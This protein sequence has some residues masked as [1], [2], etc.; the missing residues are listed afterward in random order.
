MSCLADESFVCLVG[1]F[2]PVDPEG[3]QEDFSL[4]MLIV[5]ALAVGRT[6]HEKLTLRDECHICC[7]PILDE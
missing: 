2:E 5:K 7:V 4:R 6:A 3:A 1:D